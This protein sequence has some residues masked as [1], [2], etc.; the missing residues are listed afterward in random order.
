[1]ALHS[2]WLTFGHEVKKPDDLEPALARQLA[3]LA[4]KSALPGIA[5][6]GLR[7]S[8]ETGYAG[9]CLDVEVERPQD[10]AHSI[11]AIESIAVLFPL[12]GRQPSILALR[13][14]FPE[15]PHQNLS[16]LGGPCSLC[17]DDRPWPEA[18]LTVTGYDIARRV[19]LWLSKAA[20]GELHDPTQPPDP[21]FF[22]SPL[23]LVV[24]GSIMV[25]T[26][27]PVGLD[28]WVRQDN[29]SLILTRETQPSGMPPAF[30][31]LV[32]RAHP[33]RM[34]RLRHA[35]H[36]LATLNSEL[37]H[38]GIRLY[39]Q[40]EM[41][42]KA[43]AG[44]ETAD[45][46]RLSSRLA[47]LIVFPVTAGQQP[48]VNDVRAFITFETAG[49][50]GVA[51][52][53]LCRNDSQVGDKRAY[54]AA[55][56]A[57]SPTNADLPVAPANVHF[58]LNRD[59]AAAITGRVN[60]DR[61]CAVI[62]GAGS[63]GSQ[64]SLNL[65]REGA[66]LWAV[67]DDDHLLPHNLVRHALFAEDIGAPKAGALAQKL[68]GVLGEPVAAIQSN[69]LHPDEDTTQ[70]L[71]TALTEAN[72][73]IDASASVAVSRHLS[74]LPEVN[75]RRI[76]VF[77]NPAGTSVVLLA[78]DTARS[79]TLRD[80]EAQYYRVVSSDPA[81]SD[82]LGVEGQG[83]RYSGSC[84]ALTN[85]IP[86]T[87]AALLSAL[88]ARGT[89]QAL[90]TDKATISIWTLAENGEVHLAQR[91]GAS[92]TQTQLC[93]WKVAYDAGLL[94]D[95]RVLRGA[96]LPKE[97]GGVLLGIVD[98]GRKTAYVARALPEPEDSR[99]SE[100]A[101]ER[102][103]VSLQEQV[104]DAVTATMHQLRYIGEW[105]SHPDG[106]STTPSY[107]DIAQLA[108][109]GE[110]LENEGLPGLMAIVGTNGSISFVLSGLP[111]SSGGPA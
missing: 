16:P 74:D 21:V 6:T 35:P 63:L 69:V 27:E 33:Q 105:H 18:R 82:H 58:A 95:L 31:I 34:T 51:L 70:A 25:E 100:T 64:L 1:M 12:D 60:S 67:V 42:L 14:D 26:T 87:N 59:L 98:M 52:G 76:S 28:G 39:D 20:R 80:L 46:R 62:V 30:T 65:A 17:I 36:T 111:K 37:E 81:L 61:R 73:I 83:I 55:I 79:I 44:L 41:S 104:S 38:G 110:E 109:L 22:D 84:R 32:F 43:W 94:Q 7:Q 88:A 10:L 45:I 101:F 92:V 23:N 103:I 75:A 66:F 78:E 53:V 91:E 106:A 97:T 85:R 8:P 15:T 49:E 108:W 68:A 13:E 47:V 86:A 99:A 107:T 54:I 9:V 72:V 5:L 19:Q 11:R 29:E 2:W 3:T 90:E 89:A 56:P 50:I 24:P 77:F 4:A 40:L 71:S 57:G 48:G 93:D 102:G 96:K